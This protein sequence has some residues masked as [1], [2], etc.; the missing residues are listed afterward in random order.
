ML[1][2]FT[3]EHLWRSRNL[4]LPAHSC[5]KTFSSPLCVANTRRWVTE[6]QASSSP[7]QRGGAEEQNVASQSSWQQVAVHFVP[8]R[9]VQQQQQ[10]KKVW[11]AFC[12]R[13]QRGKTVRAGKGDCGERCRKVVCL[14]L[15]VCLCCW[16]Y[17]FYSI[18]YIPYCLHYLMI[19]SCYSRRRKIR[20]TSSNDQTIKA[21]KQNFPSHAY[22]IASSEKRVAHLAICKWDAVF[23]CS[24]ALSK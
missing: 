18:Y 1:C 9:I 21:N 4:L 20:V 2:H 5:S 13:I 14:C 6:P 3:E 10:Q 15:W 7:S 11:A 23:C 19:L 12:V 8:V 22:L 16:L 17:R 24:A